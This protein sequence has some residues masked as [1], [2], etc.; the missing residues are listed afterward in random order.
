MQVR[1]ISIDLLYVAVDNVT[2]WHQ[3]LS[4][5]HERHIELSE[6]ILRQLI[7][8]CV[9]FYVS[10]ACFIDCL[11]HISRRSRICERLIRINKNYMMTFRIL[12][13][14]VVLFS[15]HFMK[16]LTVPH[17]LPSIFVILFIL[18]QSFLH[19]QKYIYP[20]NM[21]ALHPWNITPVCSKK[22]A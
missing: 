11:I 3:L 6:N 16:M 9:V 4:L 14:F 12:P 22:P 10:Y 8:V 13:L 17:R 7:E 20:S 21:E 19:D 18:L 15:F 1:N 2:A 5:Q